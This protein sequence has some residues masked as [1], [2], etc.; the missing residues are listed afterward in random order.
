[1][2][3]SKQPYCCDR[4]RL[5][6]TVNSESGL[7][8]RIVQM[9]PKYLMD[10][11]KPYRFFITPGYDGTAEFTP[12]LNIAHCPFCGVNLFDYY[13]DESFVNESEPSRLFPDQ[14]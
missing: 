11:T 12:T 14:A 8:I 2:E 5:R 9:N 1:M 3:S 13:V 10:K 4:F 7:N 6:A